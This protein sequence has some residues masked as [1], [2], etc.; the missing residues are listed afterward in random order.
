MI[1]MI[2]VF[3]TTLPSH[4]L[5]FAIASSF[6]LSFSFLSLSFFRF[7]YFIHYIFLFSFL[8][9]LL[10]FIFIIASLISFITPLFLFIIAFLLSSFSRFSSL[11]SSLFSSFFLSS[12]RHYYFFFIFFVFIHI[13]RCRFHFHMFWLRCY[14]VIIFLLLAISMLFSIRYIIYVAISSLRSFAHFLLAHFIFRYWLMFDFSFIICRAIYA[15]FSLLMITI[16]SIIFIIIFHFAIYARLIFIFWYMMIRCYF[17]AFSL[18]PCCFYTD[19][20]FHCHFIA[21]IFI[22]C[23]HYFIFIVIIGYGFLHYFFIFAIRLTFSS[24]SSSLF[25]SPLLL[26]FDIMSLVYWLLRDHIILCWCPFIISYLRRCCRAAAV[27]AYYDI[28]LFLFLWCFISFFRWCAMRHADMHCRR[29]FV[30]WYCLPDAIILYTL[31]LLFIYARCL[32]LIIFLMRC[33]RCCFIIWWCFSLCL[34]L[35]ARYFIII[36][37]MMLSY[38]LMPL[39]PCRLFSVSMIILW[40]LFSRCHITILFRWCWC[41]RRLFIFWWLFFAVLRF[42]FAAYAP[43]ITPKPPSFA[44]WCDTPMLLIRCWCSFDAYF[45][46]IIHYCFTLT[47]IIFHYCSMSHFF[48]ISIWYTM[49]RLLLWCLCL[50]FRHW[51]FRLLLFFDYFDAIDAFSAFS[52]DWWL[53]RYLMLMMPLLFRYI[54]LFSF[55]LLLVDYYYGYYLMMMPVYVFFFYLL[56]FL[57]LL[58]A[59]TLTPSSSMFFCLRYFRLLFHIFLFFLHIIDDILLPTF[60]PF[61]WWWCSIIF[62][63]RWWYWYLLFF[64]RYVSSML[65]LF[66]FH[67]SIIISII[68]RHF[69][70]HYFL[71]YSFRLFTIFLSL[72][73]WCR[74]ARICVSIFWCYAMLLRYWWCLFF[75]TLRFFTRWWC[76]CW[77]HACWFSL[78]LL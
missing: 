34:C 19:T 36:Y 76:R 44:W 72:C 33:Q 59:D 62:W 20:S 43:T 48:I 17:I 18:S 14:Y 21:L 73:D 50:L 3:T 64:L 52:F 35:R 28:W 47:I 39:R 78:M 60:S 38:C 30:W 55:S 31:M 23:R 8:H 2:I 71:H 49:L 70:Y 1:E 54:F 57:S 56:I 13:S 37:F 11:F 63:C 32:M 68:C 40:L 24:H 69:D 9:F 65:P 66:I 26:R 22:S 16:F 58:F 74:A 4:R 51:C 53:F 27:Y 67:F 77:C 25:F 15:L 6:S 42:I 12:W 45:R 75:A 5:V 29:L 46:F 10:I 41:L 7:H 61:R